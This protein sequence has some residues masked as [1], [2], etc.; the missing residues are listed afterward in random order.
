MTCLGTMVNSISWSFGRSFIFCWG[1]TC[2]FKGDFTLSPMSRHPLILV[3][4]RSPVQSQR[5]CFHPYI[6]PLQECRIHLAPALRIRV[7]PFRVPSLEISVGHGI[8]VH[9]HDPNAPLGGNVHSPSR[10]RHFHHQ[11]IVEKTS[12]AGRAPRTLAPHLPPARSGV[13]QLAGI[14]DRK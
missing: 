8:P 7:C 12:E 3:F 13:P 6:T 14:V 2:N 11:L 1:K 9:I 4:I 10:I 5:P